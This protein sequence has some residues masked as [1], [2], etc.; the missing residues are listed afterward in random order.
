MPWRIRNQPAAQGGARLVS[1]V[2]EFEV[3]VASRTWR[4]Q[5]TETPSLKLERISI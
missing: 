5:C 2:R 3:S 4:L 1:N